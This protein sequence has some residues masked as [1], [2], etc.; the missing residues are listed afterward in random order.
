LI[1]VIKDWMPITKR[2][3]VALG[4]AG[5]ALVIFV[6]WN[7]LPINNVFGGGEVN[8]AAVVLWPKVFSPNYFISLVRMRHSYDILIMILF[9]S[10]IQNG[11][12]ALMVLP[13]W[14]IFCASLAL[15]II[16]GINN[17]A[18]GLFFLWTLCNSI[19]W[20]RAPRDIDTTLIVVFLMSL[21]MLALSMS[22]FIFKNELHL[23]H[24]RDVKKMMGGE[25][26]R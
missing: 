10:L 17:L 26:L 21:S 22:L 25:D 14:R 23:R 18:I 11:A 7:F 16:L 15:R 2:N 20:D 13:L 3:R 19:H 5:L 4:F 8:I 1:A 24:E 9:L 12:I 6:T